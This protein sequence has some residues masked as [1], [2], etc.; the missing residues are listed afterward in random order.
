MTRFIGVVVVAIMLVGSGLFGLGLP[1]KG[2]GVA[3]AT[4]SRLADALVSSSVDPDPHDEPS[5][6]T[7]PVDNRM[8]VAASKVIVGGSTDPPRCDEPRGG[9]IGDRRY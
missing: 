8:M 7:S 5:I 1:G 4:P 3:D 9:H 2:Y 6:A